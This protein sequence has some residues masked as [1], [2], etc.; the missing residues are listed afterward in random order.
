MQ[1]GPERVLHDFHR[2]IYRHFFSSFA[3]ILINK[4]KC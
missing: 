1:D 3:Q 2:F 4:M